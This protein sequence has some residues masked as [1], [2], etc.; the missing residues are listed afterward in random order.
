VTAAPDADALLRPAEVAQYLRITVKTLARWADSDFFPA[1]TVI[2]TFGGHRRFR[3]A[4][5]D[6]VLTAD[7][8]TAAAVDDPVATVEAWIGAAAQR[9]AGEPC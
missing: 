9:E 3:R 7:T 5:I 8:P 2:R 6:A 4:G 1:G